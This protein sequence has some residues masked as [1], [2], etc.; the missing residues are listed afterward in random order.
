[1]SRKAIPQS[2]LLPKLFKAGIKFFLP[3]FN[4]KSSKR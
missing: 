2:G 4:G 3:H 1:M